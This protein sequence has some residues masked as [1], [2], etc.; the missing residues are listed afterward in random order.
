MLHGVTRCFMVLH[1]V[2]GCYT[3]LEGVTRVNR[4]LHGVT[5]CYV[6]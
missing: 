5:G 1:V 6:F 4:V 3:V 2:T